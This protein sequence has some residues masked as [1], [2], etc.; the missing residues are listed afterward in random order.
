M[1]RE[2]KQEKNRLKIMIPDDLR[3]F[4][5]YVNEM[6]E[7]GNELAT[8]ES[9][10]LLQSNC[11]YGGLLNESGNKYGFTYFPEKGT[12]NKWELEFSDQEIKD[13]SD[14]NVN[15]LELWACKDRDC[16]CMFLDPEDLCFKN[17]HSANVILVIRL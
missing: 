9:D 7:S 10:D 11:A 12:R 15:E 13:I 3:E 1:R 14:H 2:N 8:T 16:R 5:I 6:I 4:F 17:L